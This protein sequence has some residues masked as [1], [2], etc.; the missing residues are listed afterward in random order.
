MRTTRTIIWL[1]KQTMQP[2]QSTSMVTVEEAGVHGLKEWLIISYLQLSAGGNWFCAVSGN[3]WLT[4]SL[5][6]HP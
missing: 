1:I 3:D 2:D 4:F 5:L 6:V